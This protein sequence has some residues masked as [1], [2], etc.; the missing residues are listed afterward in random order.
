[1]CNTMCNTMPLMT[2]ALF[3]PDPLLRQQELINGTAKLMMLDVDYC[4]TY[5][6]AV[7]VGLSVLVLE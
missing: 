3:I 1:M 6:K 4:S 2:I 7:R 5:Y